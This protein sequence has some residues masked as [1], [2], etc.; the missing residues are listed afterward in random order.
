MG[1][2]CS[3]NL[4]SGAGRGIPGAKPHPESPANPEGQT[5][6]VPTSLN[7]WIFWASSS[8]GHTA[9]SWL[10]PGS[11]A[12]WACTSKDLMDPSQIRI[13]D[14]RFLSGSET[15]GGSWAGGTHNAWGYPAPYQLRPRGAGRKKVSIPAE[16]RFRREPFPL[17]WGRA[18]P[19]H[20]FNAGTSGAGLWLPWGKRDREAVTPYPHGIARVPPY[21]REAAG[22]GAMLLLGDGK[23]PELVSR[24]KGAATGARGRGLGWLKRPLLGVTAPRPRG[25]SRS[26]SVSGKCLPRAIK[27]I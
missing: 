9:E 26:P 11:T 10:V 2:V 22:L 3:A 17:S 27:T 12:A 20:A 25:A 7:P 15:P 21:A 24:G 4:P 23:G 19:C 8:H 1:R 16:T 5:L 13:P 14:G 18:G 6:A